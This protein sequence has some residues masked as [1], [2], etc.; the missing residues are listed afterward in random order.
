MSRNWE[1]PTWSPEAARSCWRVT[2]TRPFVH[3]SRSMAPDA[4]RQSVQGR[5]S[6]SVTK[7]GRYPG[8]GRGG[9]SAAAGGGEPAGNAVSR[10][11]AASAR[12]ATRRA[13]MG[14]EARACGVAGGIR[15]SLGGQDRGDGGRALQAS[16]PYLGTAMEPRSGGGRTMVPGPVV[17]RRGGQGQV[18]ETVIGVMPNPDSVFWS[19]T[20]HGL[21][22]V[23]AKSTSVPIEPSS[24]AY[25]RLPGPPCSIR[26]ISYWS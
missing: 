2:V 11:A 3:L 15:S 1:P 12:A 23:T 26:S 6:V 14:S 5:L 21:G 20:F 9:S 19:T 25:V 24:G 7:S 10:H 8:S 22:A 4:H 17:A 18:I 16:L 13:R